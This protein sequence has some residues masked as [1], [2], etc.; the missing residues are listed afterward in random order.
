MAF[1]IPT[2]ARHVEAFS[3]MTLIERESLPPVIDPADWPELSYQLDLSDGLPTFPPHRKV[4]D[5]LVLGSGRGADSIIGP[6]PPSGRVATVRDVAANA[7]MAGCLPE[8]MPVVLI[9]LE[10][11]Q[12]P[13]FNFAGVVATT[14]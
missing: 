1:T 5:A 8:H 4:V 3:D 2:D 9:A 12:E 13:R 7:A 14:H 10:A 11:M 6:M